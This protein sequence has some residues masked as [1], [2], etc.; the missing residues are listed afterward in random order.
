MTV[1]GTGELLI[2]LVIVLFLFGAKRLP[3]MARGL[4]ESIRELRR[5]LDE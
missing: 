5:S 4:G 2:I 3:E 1:P